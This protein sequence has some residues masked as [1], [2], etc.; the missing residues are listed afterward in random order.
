MV[1][2]KEGD[3]SAPRPQ[4]SDDDIDWV[5]D[6]RAKER[7]VDALTKKR[8][9]WATVIVS[10]VSLAFAILSYFKGGHTP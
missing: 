6:T 7:L 10:V 4:M 3:Y 8:F 2:G 9:T 1:R 5:H